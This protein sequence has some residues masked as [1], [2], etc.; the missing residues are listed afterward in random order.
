MG[1]APSEQVFEK[2]VQNTAH[3]PSLEGGEAY[4]SKAGMINST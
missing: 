1:R 3:V 2:W 4:V